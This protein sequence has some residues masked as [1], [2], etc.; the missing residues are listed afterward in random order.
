MPAFARARGLSWLFLARLAVL[1]ILGAFG[2]LP[3]AGASDQPPQPFGLPIACTLGKT[4]WITTYA[5]TDPSPGVSDFKCGT[6]SYDGHKGTDFG[7]GALAPTEEVPVLAA[8]PGVVARMRSD[9]DDIN[10]RSPG[11]PSVKDKECGNGVVIEHG[12]GWV[13]QYCHLRKNSI[14]VHPGEPVEAGTVLGL[15]GLSG[16]TEHPHVHFEVRHGDAIIDPFTGAPAANG[17]HV[18]AHP[19]WQ[20]NVD[21]LLAYPTPLLYNTGFAGDTPDRVGVRAG[22]YKSG[23]VA[24]DAQVLV[25]FV[26]LLAIERGDRLTVSI[27]APDGSPFVTTDYTFD[28]KGWMQWFGLAGKKRTK[29][30]WPRGTYT[31]VITVE[32]PGKGVVLWQEARGVVE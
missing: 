24:A 32:R 14:R 30:P 18:A 29:G 8:A 6:R 13:T 22:R 23:I 28:D 12:D 2:T 5:D 31:G 26:D 19:L 7:V 15:V 16:Q 10:V 4:C 17:C 3:P 21:G 25:L 1:L 20:G 9:M 27:T 11:A